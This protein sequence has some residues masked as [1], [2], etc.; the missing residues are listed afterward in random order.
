MDLPG[1]QAVHERVAPSGIEVVTVALDSGGVEAAGPWIDAASPSHPSLIDEG[2]LIDERLGVVNVPN[3]LWIDE[4]GTIVR[5]AEPAWPG[6]TPVL[7]MLDAPGELPPEAAETRKHIARMHIDPEAYLEMV[8]D[9]A[10]QGSVS[11]HVLS[12]EEVIERSRPRSPER[13][14]AAAHFELG[15]HLRKQS[16]G[17]GPPDPARQAAIVAH[18]REAHRLDPENWTY[19]RQAWNLATG[20]TVTQSEEYES[21]WLADVERVGAENYYPKLRS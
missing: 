18:W 19:K 12:P 9:W 2:H 11:R 20:D 5:P 17:T 15:Q 1:W 14:R 16:A 21:N 13:A 8:L 7:Q 4:T 10:E 3:A 6:S